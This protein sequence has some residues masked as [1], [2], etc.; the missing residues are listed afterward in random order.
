MATTLRYYGNTSIG[1][2][3][4]ATVPCGRKPTC[5][6]PSKLMDAVFKPPSSTPIAPK[7]G[8]L[9]VEVLWKR[10]DRFDV[11]CVN[12]TTM[13]DWLGGVSPST[14]PWTA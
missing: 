5:P 10:Y 8:G 6:G 13:T 11:L 9:V 12:S 1:D 3:T 4:A 7:N 2:I 14:S